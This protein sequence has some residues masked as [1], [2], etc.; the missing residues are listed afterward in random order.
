MTICY[1]AT[2]QSIESRFPAYVILD[3]S[4]ECMQ[5]RWVSA[6]WKRQNSRHAVRSLTR[7]IE[8]KRRSREARRAELGTPPARAMSRKGHRPPAIFMAPA[9][10]S[11]V[12]APDQSLE[13]F[14]RLQNF[15]AKRNIFVDLSDV[16]TITPDAIALLLSL[17]SRLTRL[18]GIVIRGNYPSNQ[19]AM[20]TIRE[21]GFDQYLKT[22]LPP[23][24]NL[25]GAIIKRDLLLQAKQADGEYARQLIDFCAKDDRNHLRL[26]QSFSHLIECMGNTHQHAADHPGIESWWASAFQDQQRQCD[27][28]TFVD[29]GVGI[30]NSIELSNRLKLYNLVSLFRPQVLRELL[31][32][33]IPSSTKLSYRG[34][35][36]PSIYGSCKSGAIGK[37][38]IVT[39]DV[40]ADVEEDRY[41]T[42][43]SGFTGVVLYWEVA[44]DS[45]KGNVQSPG[46]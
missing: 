12:A 1:H 3:Q 13:F 14:G 35:G 15:S 18:H 7:R 11:L 34:R 40:Y 41:V 23:A 6:R 44:H 24:E 45:G 37:L 38:V 2:Q 39:N 10:L 22:S 17:V 30:F 43:P 8:W 21:S 20:R 19:R 42:L 36:L 46:C 32:G 9:V 25:K 33:K 31:L 29:M 16:V 4:V 28:F 27:C 5:K 26:K